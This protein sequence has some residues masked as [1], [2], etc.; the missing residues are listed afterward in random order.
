[1]LG[2]YLPI[3]LLVAVAV[4]FGLGSIIFSS[5][6][7]PKK[8]SEVKLSPYECGVE[9]VGSARERFSIKF[10]IIAMLF[11]L[12]DIEAVFLYPWAVLFKRLGM[13][14]LMEMGVFIVIL[15]VGYIYVW[16]KGA[17]EW[18]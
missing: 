2:A 11:I 13:F 14:G 3:I 12:F 18:E 7:G 6:I 16:K 8:P 1:M 15:F 10:Y 4:A 17:L 5:L 9:P